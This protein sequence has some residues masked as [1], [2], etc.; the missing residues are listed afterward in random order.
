[1]H[2]SRFL[3]F[4]ASTAIAGWVL[5][6]NIAGCGG[7]IAGGARNEALYPVKGQVLLPTGK[8]LTAGAVVFVPRSGQDARPHGTID[9]NGDFSLKSGD[10][11][12]TPAG[13]YAVYIEPDAS[14]MKS[15]KGKVD[16]SALPFPAKYADTDGDT[17]LTATV[18]AEATTLPAFKLTAD[19][20]SEKS[21][22]RT[23]PRD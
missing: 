22:R 3:K 2:M 5:L 19:K 7:E 17:G 1:M 20:A 13:D 9:G 4:T 10:K 16:P 14:L 21:G 18:K 23:A 12:G 15:K 6:V 11:D 8:P